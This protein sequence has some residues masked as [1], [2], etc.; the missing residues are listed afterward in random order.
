MRLL[1]HQSDGGFRLTEDILDKDIYQ[2][3]YAIL[4]HRWG[5]A[6]EE[7]T[8]EEMVE[9]LGQDKVGYKK[10]EFCGEQASVDGL[11]YFWIDSCCIKRSSDRELP[12]AIL[13]SAAL[14]SLCPSRIDSKIAN[15]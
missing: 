5:C 7:V 15:F 3:P 6:N 9:G 10:I 4:S 14:A 1:E 11:K 12:E 13:F 8:F 2:Y